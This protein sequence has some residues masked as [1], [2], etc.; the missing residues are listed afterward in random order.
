MAVLPCQGEHCRADRSARRAANVR[1]SGRPRAAQC[2]ERGKGGAE[3]A[4]RCPNAFM[5]P[6]PGLAGF[7][8]ARRQGSRHQAPLPA[9]VEEGLLA[10]RAETPQSARATCACGQ[11]PSLAKVSFADDRFCLRKHEPACHAGSRF[12]FLSDGLST[13][14]ADRRVYWFRPDVGRCRGSFAHPEFHRETHVYRAS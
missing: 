2:D 14:V 3:H 10:A 11:F 4:V 1:A 13:Q 5:G 9:H 6:N 7:K 8:A 12:D